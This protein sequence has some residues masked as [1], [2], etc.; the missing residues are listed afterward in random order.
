[1]KQKKIWIL[2]AMLLLLAMVAAG[3]SSEAQVVPTPQPQATAQFMPQATAGNAVNS[4]APEN[5]V[6]YDWVNNAAQVETRIRQLSEVRDCRVLVSGDTALVGVYFD[7]SYRGE[8]TDRIR[9]MIAA[10][11]MQAD[12]MIKT[13][14]VTAE[15]DDVEDIYEMSD[16]V[17]RGGMLAELEEDIREIVREVTTLR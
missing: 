10:E 14:A 3:C 5:T 15:E 11:V 7:P 12:P 13:V 17:A 6:Q 16:R 9:E 4:A 8:M 1:M 2:C